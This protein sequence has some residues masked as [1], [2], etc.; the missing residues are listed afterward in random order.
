[1]WLE[2]RLSFKKKK[3]K[4]KKVKTRI[5]ARTTLLDK[6]NVSLYLAMEIIINNGNQDDI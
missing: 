5:I 4:K 1:M 3:K 2:L 6:E